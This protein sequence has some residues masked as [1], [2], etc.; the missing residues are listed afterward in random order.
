VARRLPFTLSA[1]DTLAGRPRELVKLLELKKGATAVVTYGNGPGGIAVIERAE[2]KDAGQT[3]PRGDRHGKVQLPTVAIGSATGSVLDTP[4][5]SVVQFSR[6][7]VSYT[8]LGSVPAAVA[9]AAAR[10]L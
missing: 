4:L 10:G 7:G 5:G 8:V 9:E 3:A 2:S 6:G 1:P